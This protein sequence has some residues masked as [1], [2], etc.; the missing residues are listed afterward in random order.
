MGLG[1]IFVISRFIYLLL[2]AS[3]YPLWTIIIFVT[4]VTPEKSSEFKDHY[5][6]WILAIKVKVK[7]KVE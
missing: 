4:F 1:N 6:F 7:V 3:V 5:G 2:R